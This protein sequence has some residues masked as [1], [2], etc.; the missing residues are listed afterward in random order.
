[1]SAGRIEVSRDVMI[2]FGQAA[3]EGNLK[4]LS[5]T[6]RKIIQTMMDGLIH[7]HKSVIL[8]NCTAM[9]LDRMMAK[10]ASE[11]K[12]SKLKQLSRGFARILGR[13]IPA[14]KLMLQG[15]AAVA[16]AQFHQ[17][18]S[19][20]TFKEMINKKKEYNTKR[21]AVKRPSGEVAKKM[22]KIA[23]LQERRLLHAKQAERE[24]AYL[25]EKRN[26]MFEEFEDFQL[27]RN[28]WISVADG[29]LKHFDF[30]TFR[31]L[32]IKR[33]D[34]VVNQAIEAAEPGIQKQ[35]DKLN[36]QGDYKAMIAILERA[37]PY[38]AGRLR[39]LRN[40][41]ENMEIRELTSDQI[42]ALRKEALSELR[43]KDKE[44]K[45]LAA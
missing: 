36:R 28:F 9:R 24:G 19:E 5:N 31:H 3:V 38:R 23:T 40:C 45:K 27:I 41:K 21:P 7:N 42:K 6:D 17:R 10:L 22:E 15:R 13:D 37:D 35:L 11:Q 12:S 16:T 25:K 34:S 39:V 18:P 43:K 32:I 33:M 2:A 1:M 4:K 29:N 8:E 14:E 30:E 44:L 20:A 26:R